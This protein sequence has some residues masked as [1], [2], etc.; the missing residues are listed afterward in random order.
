[1]LFEPMPTILFYYYY[2]LAISFT[3]TQ[4][5]FLSGLLGYNAVG[6]FLLDILLKLALGQ[7][8]EMV[9]VASTEV[10]YQSLFVNHSA[11]Q[12]FQ[13]LTHCAFSWLSGVGAPDEGGKMVKAATLHPSHHEARRTPRTVATNVSSQILG[14]MCPLE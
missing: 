13:H 11:F 8:E 7:R 1:M 14:Q 3:A 2:Y 10:W 12:T 4:T 6:S 9:S 5:T